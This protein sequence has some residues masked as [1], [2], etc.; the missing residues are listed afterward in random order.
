MRRVAFT[1]AVITAACSKSE[2][3]EP[4]KPPCAPSEPARVT[5]PIASPTDVGSA[6]LPKGVRRSIEAPSPV[7]VAWDP[8]AEPTADGG[9]PPC[10]PGAS[11]SNPVPEVQH[12]AKNGQPHGPLVTLWSTA[13]GKR[14]SYFTYVDGVMTGPQLSWDEQG[15]KTFHAMSNTKGRWVGTVT[16]WRDGKKDGE[17]GEYDENG[18]Q[19]RVTTW[20]QDQKLTTTDLECPAGTEKK[21]VERLNLSEQSQRQDRTRITCEKNGKP[22]GPYVDLYPG[23]S[24]E[25]AGTMIDGVRTGQETLYYDTG[26]KF[27]EGKR[28]KGVKVGTW[29]TWQTPFQ[30]NTT[31]KWKEEDYDAKGRVTEERTY[32]PSGAMES[33]A[34]YEN[35][36]LVDIWLGDRPARRPKKK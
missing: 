31:T 26:Q 2:N 13:S 35:G 16:R 20:F 27:I 1:L 23:G 7:P 3:A 8:M 33:G 32:L 29:I 15:R 11:G 10:P 12:C 6:A 14:K 22:N 24:L 36:E 28:V 19:I 21:V 5:P 9:F 17:V 4:S 34:W 25:I 30:S 18:K